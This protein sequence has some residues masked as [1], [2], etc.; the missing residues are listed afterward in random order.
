MNKRMLI[1]MLGAIASLCATVAFAQSSGNI[2][3]STLQ[4]VCEISASTGQQSCVDPATGQPV[5]CPTFG[6]ATPLMAATIQ[7]PS[8]SGTGLVITPSLAVGLF[9]NTKVSGSGTLTGSNSQVTGVLV[10]VTVDGQPAAPEV[11]VAAPPGA[12]GVVYE[13]RFQQL[14][15]TNLQCSGTSGCAIELVLSSMSAHSF[16]FV[17]PNLQQGTHFIDVYAT[18][19]NPP[20]TTTAAACVGPGTLTVVQV[21][22]F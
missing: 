11:A 8:G 22:A 2:A 7:T 4:T 1:L 17:F 9:T 3:F 5:S 10:T 13:Q 14:S 21:K 6:A 16:N 18:L 19:T 15:T 12:T 20:N